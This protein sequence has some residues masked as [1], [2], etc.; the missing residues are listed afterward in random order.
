LEFLNTHKD[1]IF[2]FLRYFVLLKEYPVVIR[3]SV[4]QMK[5]PFF[6]IKYKLY[7]NEDNILGLK[8][9]MYDLPNLNK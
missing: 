7:F 8:M 9:S 2:K 3:S 4:F 1:H 5:T 6:T